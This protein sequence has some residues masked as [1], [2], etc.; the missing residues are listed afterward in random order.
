MP[1]PSVPGEDKAAGGGLRHDLQVVLDRQQGGQRSADE[2]LV[3]GEEHAD[4]G[5]GVSAVTPGPRWPGPG[6]TAAAPQAGRLASSRKWP[7]RGCPVVM[8]PPRPASRSPSPASPLPPDPAA[9]VCTRSLSMLS[10]TA[11]GAPGESR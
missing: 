9:G 8:L 1:G 3:V 2:V 4:H 11:R 7:L 5:A 6:G 10:V